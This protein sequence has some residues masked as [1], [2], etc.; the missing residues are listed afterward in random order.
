MGNFLCLEK[1][2]RLSTGFCDSFGLCVLLFSFI[3]CCPGQG[4]PVAGFMFFSCPC[5]RLDMVYLANMERQ[6][7]LS[8]VCI[9][10]CR[11]FLYQPRVYFPIPGAHFRLFFYVI[12]AKRLPAVEKTCPFL[13]PGWASGHDSLFATNNRQQLEGSL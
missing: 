2:G 10:V 6:I 12:L 1:T 5:R 11:R 13:N 8:P 7:R 3:L 9:G 4:I